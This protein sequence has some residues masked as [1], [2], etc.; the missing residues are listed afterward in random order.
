M[1]YFKVTTEQMAKELSTLIYTVMYPP[2]IE[3]ETQY[4]FGWLPYNEEWV[5]AIPENY[6]CPV[7]IKD[8]FNAVIEQLSAIIG[9]ALAEGEGQQ[10][11]AKL[12]TNSIILEEIIPSGLVEI[13]EQDFLATLP[14][15]PI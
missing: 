12:S 2:N 8:N 9:F 6:H 10:I 5:I 4:L 13:P 11:V 1:K 15:L 14:K 7:F 3:N